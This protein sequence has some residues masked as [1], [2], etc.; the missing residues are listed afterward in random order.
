MITTTPYNQL[1]T[2]VTCTWWSATLRQPWSQEWLTSTWRT[3]STGTHCSVSVRPALVLRKEW[4]HNAGNCYVNGWKAI[5]NIHSF[6]DPSSVWSL[7][8]FKPA[9]RQLLQLPASHISRCYTASDIAATEWHLH[10]TTWMNMRALSLKSSVK[11]GHLYSDMTFGNRHCTLLLSSGSRRRR[12][13][14]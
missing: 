2:T 13:L 5:S 8:K 7:S 4:K 14:T 3:C 10:T 9:G 12:T 11:T 1:K 6:S